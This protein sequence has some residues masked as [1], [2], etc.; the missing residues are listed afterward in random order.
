MWHEALEQA[1]RRYFFHEAT[2]VEA[3][4]GVLQVRRDRG[5]LSISASLTYDGG[6]FFCSRSTRG[7]TRAPPP[8]R[9]APSSPRM[10]PTCTPR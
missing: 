1:Y 9:S 6:H 7:S 3:M 8:P 2:G 10:A 5:S 4:L